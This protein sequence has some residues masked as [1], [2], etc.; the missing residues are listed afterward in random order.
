MIRPVLPTN[1]RFFHSR[2][3]LCAGSPGAAVCVAV[4]RNSD[5]SFVLGLKDVLEPVLFSS[6]FWAACRDV[7][8]FFVWVC[9][10]NVARA[11][12]PDG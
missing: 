11:E 4:P 5:M 6:S 8:F 7:R 1:V 10:I 3:E 2:A 12:V 9:Y